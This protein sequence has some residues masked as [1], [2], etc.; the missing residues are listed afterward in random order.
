[1]RVAE[2]RCACRCC[3]EG[4]S[5][6]RSTTSRRHGSRCRFPAIRLQCSASQ[7]APP[8]ARRECAMMPAV[9]DTSAGLPCLSFRALL[10]A[11]SPA[12][13]PC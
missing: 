9:C 10:I 2:V 1:M 7:S 4:C 5:G 8:A 11:H 12:I 6:R 13:C 3:L